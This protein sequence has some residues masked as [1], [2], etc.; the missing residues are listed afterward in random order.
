MFYLNKQTMRWPISVLNP[1]FIISSVRV[2]PQQEK[3]WDGSIG[4]IHIFCQWKPQQ[5]HSNVQPTELNWT[6]WQKHN[7]C[8]T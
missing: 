5:Y 3:R 1:P 2:E 7:F 6:A 8:E 4:T